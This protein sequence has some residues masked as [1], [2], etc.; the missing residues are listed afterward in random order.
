MLVWSV[1]DLYTFWELRRIVAVLY[2]AYKI[3]ASVRN[4]HKTYYC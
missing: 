4:S 2:K 1:E 3:L